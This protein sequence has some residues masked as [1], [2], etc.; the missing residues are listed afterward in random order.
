[1]GLRLVDGVDLPLMRQRHNV[2]IWG[3]YGQ[4]LAPFVQAGMLVHEPGRRL[5][6][7]RAGML[8]ANEV[9]SVFIG[10]TVR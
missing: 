5:A 2:D 4:H 3:R 8:L 7:T 1:M 9:M 6:L 10:R